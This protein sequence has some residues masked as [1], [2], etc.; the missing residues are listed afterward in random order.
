MA[1]TGGGTAAFVSDQAVARLES[2]SGAAPTAVPVARRAAGSS[3]SLRE[4]LFSD[5][6]AFSFLQA[7]R[8]LEKLAPDRV[9]VGAA[10]PPAAEV[11]R[12]RAHMSLAFPASQIYEIQ[13]ATEKRPLPTLTATF[14]G[15]TGPSGV[16][17]AHY[18]ELLIRLHRGDHGP[19]QNALRDWLDLF[20]HRLISLFY[21]AWQ[22][23]RF[24]VP[25][26]R[27]AYA[28]LDPDPFTRCLFSLVGLGTPALRNRLHVRAQ[29]QRRAAAHDHSRAALLAAV[30]DLSLLHYAGLLA[31]RPRCAVGLEALLNDYFALPV[32]VCQFEGQW[33]KLDESNQSAL[34]PGHNNRLGADVIAGER[35][36][37]VQGKI[38]LR[39][40]PLDYESFTAFTPDRAPVRERKAFFLLVH[41]VRLYVGPELSF[42][43]QLVLQAAEVP[44]CQLTPDGPR[45]G[46][47]TWAGS[48]PRTEDAADACF[49]GEDVFVLD[50]P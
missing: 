43:V 7:V 24:W 22:K 28:A 27:G 18:T 35:V 32:K 47:N 33:L 50:S 1:T 30:E 42:D 48:L 8:L 21:R 17:P 15:L 6:Y 46:W 11:V 37:D 10:G 16:L 4:Q 20:N 36:W 38:R 25:Y 40:G 26:E 45:L 2:G 29:P 49:D 44:E 23:Y 3:P 34:E 5:G 39:L 19:E 13:A 12:F 41:L 14:L 9:P 31:H